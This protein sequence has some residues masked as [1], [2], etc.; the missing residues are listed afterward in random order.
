MKIDSTP[1]YHYH[2]VFIKPQFSEVLSRKDVDISQKL[3]GKKVRVPIV[4]AN[5]DTVTDGAFAV[6]TTHAGALAAL[7]RFM[8]VEDNIKEYLLFKQHHKT[9]ECFCSIG[10]NLEEMER[11]K[12]LYEVGARW[13]IIDIAHGASQNV[14]L[15]LKRLQDFSKV[16]GQGKDFKVVVGNFA[17]PRTVHYFLDSDFSKFVDGYKIGVGPGAVCT[18]KNVT[19]VTVPQF[20]AVVECVKTIRDFDSID[21]FNRVI[22]ADGGVREIGDIAKA[23]GAGADL[24]MVGKLFAECS[25]S[26]AGREAFATGHAPVYRGMA[27]AAAMIDF[28]GKVSCTPEG[29]ETTV[30]CSKTV[31]D[32]VKNVEGGL[33]SSFS[34]CNKRTFKGFCGNVEFGVRYSE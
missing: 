7:H 30:E 34:Y 12:K 4:S 13:F 33:Q 22:I 19:G 28:K 14:M 32:F 5:M 21:G 11:F 6:H 3:W 20:T 29:K 26:V 15:M 2:N 16:S 8:S 10:T 1:S 23:I 31:A 17:N 18:T 27:S 24:V 9:K 25:D